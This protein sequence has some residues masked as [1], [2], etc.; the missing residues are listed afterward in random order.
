[1]TVNPQ[2]LHLVLVAV[3][4]ALIVATAQTSPMHKLVEDGFARA[5]GHD[6]ARSITHAGK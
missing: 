6:I 3:L 5:F 2:N 1:M 4:L